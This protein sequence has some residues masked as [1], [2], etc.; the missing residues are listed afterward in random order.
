MSCKM[1]IPTFGV[2]EE[3]I[4][5]D[6]ITGAPL[7]ESTA[8]RHVA[9]SLGLDL[10]LEITPCQIETATPVLNTSSE[11][12]HHILSSRRTAESAARE[13][14]G[15]LLASGLPP[16]SGDIRPVSGT[17]RYQ[18]LAANFGLLAC[19]QGVSGCHVHVAVPDRGR[20]IAVISRSRRWLPVLLA[21]TAN[22]ALHNAT[23][24]GY[25]SWRMVLWSRWPTADCPPHF[26][27]ENDYDTAIARMIAVGAALDE[28]MIYWD[29]RYSGKFQ[30]VEFRVSDV[31]ATAD[32]TVLC[33]TLVRALV[34]TELAALQRNDDPPPA[35]DTSW[36]R[37][38]K[39]RAARD[40]ITGMCPDPLSGSMVDTRTAVDHLVR[41]VSD[42]LDLLGD[43]TMVTDTIEK[44]FTSGNGA[45]HQRRAFHL[46]GIEAV[47]DHVATR[48]IA[49]TLEPGPGTLETEGGTDACMAGEES[50]S[51]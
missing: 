39:W 38:A 28:G 15:R 2:E 18:L 13:M 16:M 48:T 45:V 7:M 36:L 9:K 40:G 30:T 44:V 17:D 34:M 21:L 20:G 26:E 47:L 50:R 31:P 22:S 29:I 10:Q 25:S 5:V 37:L 19:E 11:L 35:V 32:E 46:G 6:P 3:L 12:R 41:H 1:D 33:A 51:C 27:S 49:D 42:A 43:H 14:G 4:L 24:T 8:V 23:D